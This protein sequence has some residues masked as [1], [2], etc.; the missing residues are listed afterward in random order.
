MRRS[1]SMKLMFPWNAIAC[2]SLITCMNVDA[3]ESWTSFAPPSSGSVN[4]SLYG[5]LPWRTGSSFTDNTFNIRY[6]PS[7]EVVK[8]SK[9][10][11]TSKPKRVSVN[12]WKYSSRWNSVGSYS[13]NERPW[14]NIPNEKPDRNKKKSQQVS[15]QQWN[16][17]PAY[18]AGRDTLLSNGGYGMNNVGLT[19][20]QFTSSVVTPMLYPGGLYADNLYMGG[21]GYPGVYPG[22]LYG[23]NLY[24]HRY[25]GLYPYPG[26]GR[27]GRW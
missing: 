19:S 23:P 20:L 1:Y 17:Y 9:F 11:N 13:K 2:A 27:F 6:A 3:A 21:Y 10:T 5:E 4:K 24:N 7:A 26:I 15:Y 16:I 8:E 22:G 25:R 18:N 12:P 14:G